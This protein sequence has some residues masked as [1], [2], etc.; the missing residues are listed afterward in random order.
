MKRSKGSD[1]GRAGSWSESTPPF[2]D[3]NQALCAGGVIWAQPQ[4]AA[5]SVWNGSLVRLRRI[6]M[7]VIE[8]AP[9]PLATLNLTGRVA[10]FITRLDKLVFQT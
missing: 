9:K 10:N 4:F 6:T 5:Y 2:E 8:Q 7:V 3:P 1:L